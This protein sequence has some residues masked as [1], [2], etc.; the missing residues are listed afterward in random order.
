MFYCTSKAWTAKS[1]RGSRSEADRWLDRGKGKWR[2]KVED[3]K[4]AVMGVLSYCCAG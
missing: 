4:E 1:T 2:E 3:I